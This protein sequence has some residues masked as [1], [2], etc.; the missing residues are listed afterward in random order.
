MPT[1]R[2]SVAGAAGRFLVAGLANTAL[3]ALALVVLSLWLDPRVAYTVVFAAGV[4]LAVVLAD[5]YVYG[6]RMGRRIRWAYALLYVAVYLVGLGVVEMIRRSTVPAPWSA[7]VVLVTA[8]LTFLGGR[9]L[10]RHSPIRSE[11]S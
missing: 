8:P 6:V 5:R 2:P 10:T 3:T 4:V 1:Q 9:L 7:A 11:D